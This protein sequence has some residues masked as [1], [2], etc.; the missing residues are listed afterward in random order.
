MSGS[1][2]LSPLP[3]PLSRNCSALISNIVEERESI[4]INKKDRGFLLFEISYRRRESGTREK[5]SSR[6]INLEYNTYVQESNA[7]NFPLQPGGFKKAKERMLKKSCKPGGKKTLRAIRL[8][9]N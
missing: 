1:G 9:M 8:K 2:H 6:R 7:S 3:P 4:N 5:I